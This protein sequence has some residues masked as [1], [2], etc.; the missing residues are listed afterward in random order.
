LTRILLLHKVVLLF[1]SLLM[2]G[3]ALTRPSAA[4]DGVPVKEE[5]VQKGA[6]ISF[7]VSPMNS[8]MLREGELAEVSFRITDETTGNPIQ[9]L[10]PGAWIDARGESRPGKKEGQLSCREKV[11]LYVQGLVGYRPLIDLTSYF[12]LALNNDPTI[13]VVDP[14]KGITGKTQLFTMI[15]LKSAGE[16]WVMSADEK[17]LFVTMPKVNMVAVADL[18]SFKVVKNI[19]VGTN[20]VRAAL[21]P[22][23]KY[24]WVGNDGSKKESGSVTVI[25]S[26]GLMSVA[27]IP[28]GSGRHEITFSDDSL[29]AFVANREKGTVTIVDTQRLEK[30][31]EIGTGKLPSSMDYS[32][33][34][35]A[36]FVAHEGDGAIAVID[37]AKHEIRAKIATKPGLKAIRFDPSGRWGFAVNAAESLVY[38]I[39]GSTNAVAYTVEVA[40]EPDGVVFT[41]AFAYVRS[42]QTTEIRMISLKDLGKEKSLPTVTI[43]GG[44][45]PP[46]AS[47]HT[48]VAD[49]IVRSQEYN[50]V[51]ITNP[52]DRQIYYYTE[53]MAA[54][55]G[56]FRG[57]GGAAQR[58]ALVINRVLRTTEPGLYSARIRIPSRGGY[59]VAFLLDSPQIVHC[60]SFSAQPNPVLARKDGGMRV[61]FLTRER[62]VTVGREFR[63]QLRVTDS[64]SDEPLRNIRDLI[65]Q[66]A[67]TPGGRFDRH[68]AEHIADGVY[69]VVFTIKSPGAYYVTLSVPSM[70]G[71][72][73]KLPHLIL[74]A[75]GEKRPE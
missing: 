31:K 21:Q 25:D 10:N 60:F 16:D 66:T 4:E 26:G 7:S 58:A 15:Y 43:T 11:K 33:L 1:L 35:G 47:P 36:V 46:A 45:R 52:A 54:S 6:R 3:A 49:P 28:T 67:V 27:E 23:G 53:G 42:R 62:E 74:R 13:S 72:A 14:I 37:G 50:T 9:A 22:D 39:D 71:D 69:E 8:N 18:E 73:K 59:D 40:K 70:K 30:I 17:K 19:P 34:T 44:Q 5:L 24:L 12:I 20:P 29:Y 2:A 65:V 56:S 51:L 75:T 55:M 61:E 41:D 63:L 38:I 64:S 57:Y 68:R 48:S 32:A